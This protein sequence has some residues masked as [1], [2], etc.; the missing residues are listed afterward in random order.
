MAAAGISA[1]MMVGQIQA[2]NKVAPAANEALLL[3]IDSWVRANACAP[4][5]DD[6]GRLIAEVRSSCNFDVEVKARSIEARLGNS[7]AAST[8]GQQELLHPENYT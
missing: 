4:S 5:A 1:E 3:Q 8:T 6:L 7:I 2:A